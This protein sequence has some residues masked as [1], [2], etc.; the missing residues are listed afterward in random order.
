MLIQE[1]YMSCDNCGECYPHSSLD[2]Q[3]AIDRATKDGW[4]IN[5]QD[6]CPICDKETPNVRV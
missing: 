1:F 6:L 3:T 5:D 2:G 4:T